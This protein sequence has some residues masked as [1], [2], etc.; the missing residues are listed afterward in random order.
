M[1]EGGREGP[2]EG[3]EGECGFNL[4]RQGSKVVQS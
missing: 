3:K 1:S 2:K 4:E